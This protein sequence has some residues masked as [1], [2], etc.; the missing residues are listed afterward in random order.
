MQFPDGRYVGT[1]LAFLI[2]RGYEH[3]KLGYLITA[4]HNCC[5]VQHSIDEESEDPSTGEL[6]YADHIWFELKRNEKELAFEEQ[7]QIIKK[8][9]IYNKILSTAKDAKL[10]NIIRKKS[11]D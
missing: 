2:H 8:S 11:N 10:R 7:F 3:N 6:V 9:D 1:A 4:A 5:H